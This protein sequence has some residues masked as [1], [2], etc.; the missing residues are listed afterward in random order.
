M[1]KLDIALKETKDFF[2]RAFRERDLIPILGS[3]FSCGMQARGTAKVPSGSKLKKDIY[4][5]FYQYY[6]VGVKSTSNYVP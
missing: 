1:E 2:V 6:D 3:G 4:D 5:Y